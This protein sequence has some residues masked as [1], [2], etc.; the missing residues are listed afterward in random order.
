MG[1][2]YRRLCAVERILGAD[3]N[4]QLALLL[5]N[6]EFA[7]KIEDIARKC[8]QGKLK[9]FTEADVLLARSIRLNA[10]YALVEGMKKLGRRPLLDRVEPG[11]SEESPLEAKG[12]A[13]RRVDVLRRDPR[14]AAMSARQAL[15]EARED[16]HVY[17][18]DQRCFESIQRCLDLELSLATDHKE[19]K[20]AFQHALERTAVME[21]P[22]RT[23]FMKFFMEW[24]GLVIST[25]LWPEHNGC[26]W[27]INWLGSVRTRI[28]EGT[29]GSQT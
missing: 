16:H 7:N 11:D 19:R 4:R 10:E 15:T 28:S 13:R 1:A 25:C 9:N 29:T 14:T 18:P 6:W 2:D 22:R 8:L 3:P 27:S 23:T 12:M 21:A 26:G 24:V 5:A 17:M 20:A